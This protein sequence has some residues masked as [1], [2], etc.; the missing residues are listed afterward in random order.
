MADTTT[1]KKKIDANEVLAVG[2]SDTSL[3]STDAVTAS[4]NKAA[5]WQ[6]QSDAYSKQADE[7][8]EKYSN[9]GNF[10]YDFNV[11][12]VFQAAKQAYERSAKL[13]AEDVQGKAAA[14]SG[15]Y[16]NSYG[17][18][19]AQQA[20]NQSIDNLYDTIPEL[21]AAAYNRY[22]NEQQRNLTLY[23]A[24]Q[25][26]ADSA[27]N[28]AINAENKAY[29]YALQLAE[30]GQY[31]KLGEFLGVDLSAVQND[32]EY[33]KK[34][35]V[36]LQKAEVGDYSGLVDLGIDVS[37]LEAKD[38]LEKAQIAA[39][40]GD[41]TL[42]KNA[43]ID[44]SALEYERNFTNALQ[45]AQYGDYSGLE[46]L[47]YDMSTQKNRDLLAWA[48]AAAETGDYSLFKE[49]GFDTSAI[50]YEQKLNTALQLAQVGD[51]SALKALGVDVSA[52]TTKSSSSGSSSSSKSSSGKMTASQISSAAKTVKSNFLGDYEANYTEG[53]VT[54]EEIN[55]FN[56]ALVMAN[57]DA[58]TVDSILVQAGIPTSRIDALWDYAING[59]TGEPKTNN[60]AGKGATG[61]KITYTPP[62]SQPADLTTD[63][64]RK[65]KFRK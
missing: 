55:A 24:Y 51:N 12:P 32:A 56:S 33:Q 38:T 30:M 8:L 35:N 40:Y 53:A 7:Y 14:L 16:A 28:K 2:E 4:N 3:N 25:G 52:L 1:K 63:D 27:E 48:Q 54:T 21:E 45:M 46:A 9:N 26:K 39:T 18:T 44:T 61:N 6:A 10:S 62:A 20:Y 11:D 57:Y 41:F 19:A 60:S 50:E 49:L 22:Q 65:E 43:G 37:K 5:D 64:A 31:G 34:L 58:D 29:S 13:A 15:G 47:G 42:L 36:A 59:S 23:E 17:V